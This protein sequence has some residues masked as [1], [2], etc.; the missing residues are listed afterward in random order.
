[1]TQSDVLELRPHVAD[2]DEPPRTDTGNAE[3]FVIDHHRGTRFVHTWRKWVLW[4]T[5]RWAVDTTGAIVRLAEETIRGLYHRAYEL[6]DKYEREQL[7]KWALRSEAEPKLRA[8]L[9]L[10]ACD[11]SIAIEASALDT[12]PT[13][14]NVLNGTIDL[15]SGKLLP[16]FSR[17]L[18]TKLAPM[19]Y[20]ET[21]GCPRFLEFLEE[22]LPDPAVRTFVQRAVGYSLTAMTSERCLFILHGTGANGKSTFLEVIRRLLGDYARQADVS[23]FMRTRNDTGPRPEVVR[24]RG[25]RFISSVE[26]EEGRRLAESLVK[27]LTGNDTIAARGLYADVVEFLPTFKVW[28]GT[29]HK[30]EIRGTDNAIWDRIRLI[31]FTVTIPPE[32]QDKGLPDALTTELPGILAWAVEGCLA[33]QQEGLSAPDAVRMATASYRDEMDVV[34]RFLDERCRVSPVAAVGSTDL[35]TAYKEWAQNG[36]ERPMTQTRFGRR[37]GDLGF[38]N[39]TGGGQGRKQYLGLKLEETPR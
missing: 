30:P 15:Q 1:M 18:I 9:K 34:Q 31:P 14:F 26:V 13:Y 8:M 2:A 5:K 37:M 16:H 24:L 21:A 36:G 6:D 20:G 7:A 28:L 22:V 4:D 11:L 12:K 35:Y 25:A 19:E 39:N 33:W 3:R 38:Q 27:A 29:N 32:R 17:D 10:A 23:T